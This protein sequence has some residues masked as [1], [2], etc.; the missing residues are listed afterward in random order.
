MD[1]KIESGMSARQIFTTLADKFRQLSTPMKV[2]VGVGSA[3]VIAAPVIAFAFYPA[4]ALGVLTAAAVGFGLEAI[5]DMLFNRKTKPASEKRLYDEQAADK[6]ETR[7]FF[8]LSLSRCFNP[9]KSGA[10]N[11]AAPQNDSQPQLTSG[12]PKL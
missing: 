8:G 3:W 6:A 4:A 2:L 7:R 9:Q 1:N 11:D 10:R 12:T 5:G